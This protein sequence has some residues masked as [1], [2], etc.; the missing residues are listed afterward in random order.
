MKT[1]Y[2]TIKEEMDI[3]KGLE[4]L[5][6]MKGINVYEIRNNDLE[7]LMF[8]R[9]NCGEDELEQ[10]IRDELLWRDVIDGDFKLKRL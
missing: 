4:I 8:V 1:L 9:T 2:Y 3:L 10:E 7:L 5:S 6:G